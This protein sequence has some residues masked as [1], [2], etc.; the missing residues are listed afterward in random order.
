MAAAAAT[1]VG[2]VAWKALYLGRGGSVINPIGRLKHLT[3]TLLILSL[4]F[5]AQT[6]G[7][8]YTYCVYIICLWTWIGISIYANS[9]IYMYA[10]AD[11]T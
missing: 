10:F 2:S 4:L 7:H 1:S 9:L 8:V 5:A 6:E 11:M 3:S